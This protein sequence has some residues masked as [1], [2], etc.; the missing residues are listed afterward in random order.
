MSRVVAPGGL[1]FVYPEIVRG[2]TK[3]QAGWSVIE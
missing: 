2:N 1:S 3:P